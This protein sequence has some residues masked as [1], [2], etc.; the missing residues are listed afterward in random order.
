MSVNTPV[1]WNSNMYHSKE[2]AEI[3]EGVVDVYLGDFKY[4]NDKCALEYSQ[5]KNYMEVVQ[6][7]FEFAYKTA[8][9][10]LLHLVLPGHLDCCTRP[11]TEWV[12]GNI[13]QIR[14]NLMFQYRPCYRAMEYPDLGRQLTLEEETDAI[15]IVRGVGIEDLLI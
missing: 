12:A 10:L 6:P 9:I 4:G 3:L 5:V 2:I 14:F 15:D 11:I 13:P 8:E 7:N 1:V